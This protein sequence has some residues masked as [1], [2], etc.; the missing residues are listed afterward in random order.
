MKPSRFLSV[1]SILSM[2][3][4]M[5]GT[6]FSF[7]TIARGSSNG[8][9]QA[10]SS[11]IA[12]VNVTVSLLYAGHSLIPMNDSDIY[13]AYENECIDNANYGACQVY[14]ID[15]EN[16]G[17]QFDY[18]GSIN[19]N[20]GNIENLNFIVLDEDDQAYSPITRITTGTDLDLGDAFTLHKDENRQFKLLIWLSNYNF[21][22][23]PIDGAGTYNALISFKSVNGYKITGSISGS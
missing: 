7:F 18:Q 5:I 10:N 16:N 9:L 14:T 3:F 23:S 17:D 2:I 8:A 1:I 19:F 22:Q 12:G 15:I 4:I 21:N 6:T 20:I 11:E 13:K